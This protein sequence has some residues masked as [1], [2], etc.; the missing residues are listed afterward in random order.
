[1]AL[2]G[3]LVLLFAA[4]T[5]GRVLEVRRLTHRAMVEG[6]PE[7]VVHHAVDHWC[8]AHARSPA[9]CRHDVGRVGHRLHSPCDDECGLTEADVTVGHGDGGHSRQAHLVDRRRRD[10]HR[11]P[12]ATGGLT[13]GDLTGPGLDHVAEK[14]LIDPGG[15]EAGSSQGCGDRRR[16]EI[17]GMQWLECPAEATHGCSGD[18]GD[19]CW[20]ESPLGDG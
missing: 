8:F 7:A 3:P 2:G 18:S 12:G 20:H 11:H 16:T 5:E 13:R 17:N 4:D 15:I 10:R 14:D 6:A 1:V 9:C 19:D